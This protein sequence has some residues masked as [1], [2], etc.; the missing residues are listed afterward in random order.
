[1]ISQNVAIYVNFSLKVNCVKTISN[2]NN[3]NA[4]SV[5]FAKNYTNIFAINENTN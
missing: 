5:N 3:F 2:L 1:M 4:Q